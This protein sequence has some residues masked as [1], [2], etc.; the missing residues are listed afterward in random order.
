MRRT[1]SPACRGVRDTA[2]SAWTVR[3]PTSCPDDSFVREVFHEIQ[4]NN[5]RALVCHRVTGTQRKGGGVFLYF[6]VSLFLCIPVTLWQTNARVLS[7]LI[8]IAGFTLLDISTNRTTAADSR[9]ARECAPPAP[10]ARA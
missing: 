1:S 10:G 6:I 8:W 2:M 3:T 4:T 7:V 5:I 9:L